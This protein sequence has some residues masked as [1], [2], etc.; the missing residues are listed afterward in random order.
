M[1]DLGAI[2]HVKKS[3][4]QYDAHAYS[5]TDECHE[6]N[7][8]IKFNGGAAYIKLEAKGSGDVPC[9][10]KKGDGSVFQVKI[11][12]TPSGSISETT[13]KGSKQ[14]NFTVPAQIHVLHAQISHDGKTSNV[15]V[16]VTPNKTYTLY[17]QSFIGFIAAGH[18]ISEENVIIW[19]REVG[20]APATLTISWSSEINTHT[21]DVNDY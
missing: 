11:E 12:A 18:Y 4:V 20:K 5:T 2:F 6:P 10:V 15:Y 1:S 16:G 3:G 14:F 17:I 8:K 7:L 21:P 9:Y 19:Y 13:T